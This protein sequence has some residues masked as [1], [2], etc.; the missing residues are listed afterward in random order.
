M[1]SI[2]KTDIEAFTYPE[3]VAGAVE[4]ALDAAPED[5]GLV[6]RDGQQVIR[7]EIVRIGGGKKVRAE[8][9]ADEGASDE[10]IHEHAVK[11]LAQAVERL[12]G[13]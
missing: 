3:E 4:D 5:S 6:P 2:V 7:A 8:F 9:L 13:E 11:A 12:S 10:V 1:V